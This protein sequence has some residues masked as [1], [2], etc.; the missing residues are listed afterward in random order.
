MPNRLAVE[1]SLYLRQ[2]AGN[3][4]AWRAWNAAALAEARAQDRPI[5]L[6]IG[7][8]ACHWCHVMAHESFE[9][10]D[11][12]ALMDRLYVP[13]KVD[14]EERPDLDRIYQ[15]AH[16]ALTRRAG[17]WPLTVFLDPHSLLPFFAGTYF[18]PTPRHGLP[19]FADVLRGARQWWDERREQV[20]SQNSALHEFLAGAGQAGKHAGELSNSPL[21]AARDQ[22]SAGFDADNGGHR[23]APKF[24]HSGEIE[25][26][27]ALARNGDA[28]AGRMAS[29]TLSCMAGRGLQDAL[30]GGF[31]RYCVDQRWDIP[32]FEK[33]LYDNA[34]LLPAYAE[35][36]KLFESAQ[37]DRAATGI[38]QWL[39]E[40]MRAQGGG[41]CSALDADSEGVE[42]KFY[43]WSRADFEAAIE[44]GLREIAS[45]Q[46]GLDREANFEGEA[47]HL[48][49]LDTSDGIGG[50]RQQMLEHRNR[51][52]R[53][54]RDD[55][56]LTAWNALLCTGLARAG[57]LLQ[58]EAWID[59]AIDIFDVVVQHM[60][61]RGR[62]PAVLGSAGPGFLDD[63][64]YALQAA[65]SLLRARWSTSTLTR[66][67]QLAD[68]LLRDFADRDA[69][70]FFFTANDHE[71]LP[72]R[73]K[74]WLDEST[75]AGNGVAA[76]ALLQ[77]GY[78]LAE[79]RY[80]DAAEGTLRSG[81]VTVCEVPQAA[82]AMLAA[83][84]EFRAP[85]PLVVVRGDADALPAWLDGVRAAITVPLHVYA[86]PDSS[87]A[88]PPAL[89]AKPRRANGEAVLCRG[90]TCLASCADVQTLATQ[91][92]RMIAALRG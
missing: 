63:H 61:S 76:L 64:A 25:S 70:G 67:V 87:A 51:R 50:A 31:F 84:Q 35:A 14:R 6:S 33:M 69:G 15:L 9:D 36:A 17:G 42:G 3:P 34:L 26:L 44:P 39:Q 81:W 74:P 82:A 29:T 78:L 77:L 65:L 72:Q 38:V 56:R 4:V 52:V 46:F 58:R 60:D 86:I 22:A 10:A 54:A 91:V 23:G 12:G 19:A 79:I 49:A 20:Q 16:Q 32:H 68:T 83:L 66:A 7:Y 40:E 13:I 24:P 1:S 92:A 37:F 27:L 43:L 57:S 59:E 45:T 48:H 85:T 28:D 41:F 80:L 90:T 62:L 21:L 75:P 71:A 47:W 53:P 88:L 8:S 55:K 11:T 2:H 5:L 30:A 73:P 18:P 89:A